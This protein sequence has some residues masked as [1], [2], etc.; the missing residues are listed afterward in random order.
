MKMRKAAAPAQTV[1]AEE[2]AG[3]VRSG[4]WLD[5]YGSFNQP[6][7]F[8]TAL[9]ARITELSDLKIRSALTMR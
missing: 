9:G 1:S 6:D 4:M 5:Y 7:L 3:L 8:D 2:A